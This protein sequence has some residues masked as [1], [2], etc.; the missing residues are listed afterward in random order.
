MSENLYKILE[1]KLF[2]FVQKPGRYTGGEQNTVAKNGAKLN[3]VLCF[4]ELYD[5][6]MSHYGSQILY[7]IVNSNE[8]WALERA[9]MPWED[10]EEIMRKNDIP[11][12]SLESFSPVR[13][14]DFVGFSLQYELQYT[15]VLAMLDLARISIWAKDR[16]E[17]EPIIIAG[18]IVLANPEP[19][20]DFFDVIFA[21]DGEKTIVEFCKIMQDCKEKKL[22]RK[23][24]LV[25]IAKIPNAYIPQNYEVKNTGK[26][27]TVE[28]EK[29]VVFAKSEELFEEYIPQKQIAPIV[30]TVH[31]RAAV[32]IMRGCTRGCRFCAAGYYYRPIRERKVGDIL[33]QIALSVK[34]TGWDEVGLLSL[35]TADYSQFAPLLCE[36]KNG[37]FDGVKIGIPSTRIDAM[38]ENTQI[39]L[40]EISQSSSLTIAPEA[41]SQRLRNVINKDFTAQKIFETVEILAKRK[42]NTI[43]LYFMVGLPTETDVD[44][45]EMIGLI[46]ECGKIVYSLTKRCTINVSL[47][48]FSPKPHTP[49]QWEE[50]CDLQT[51]LQRCIRVKN[52]LKSIKSINVSYRDTTLS[53]CESV[54]ARGD[55]QLSKFIYELFLNGAKFEGWNDKLSI[56]LWKKCAKNCDIDLEKYTQKIDV[57]QKLPW[58]VISTGVN[59]K[60]LLEERDKA[61]LQTT[62]K[63]CRDGCNSCGVCK[64]GIKMKIEKE[65]PECVIQEKKAKNFE[66][67]TKYKIRISYKKTGR[68]RFI[69]HRNLMDCVARAL[70]ASQTPVVFSQGFRSHPKI[71]FAQP[72]PLNA[73]GENEL[74]DVMVWDA[75]SV[76]IAKI[77]SFLPQGIELFSQ[78]LVDIKENSIEQSTAFTDWKI[79]KINGENSNVYFENALRDFLSREKIEI[80]TRK[81]EEDVLLT[82]VASEIKNLSVSGG[83]S[84][85]LPAGV[86]Y[87]PADVAKA[88]FPQS[89][90]LDFIIIRKNIGLAAQCGNES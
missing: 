21:G 60:F 59:E 55:R 83:I 61:Y 11:L 50:L 9:Y 65:S 64:S 72:L 7:H 41:G 38:D 12:Y 27:V 39:L 75:K 82:V 73:V 17:D 66:G 56:D 2:P 29:P 44:I 54:L 90:A 33:K 6:G 86:K 76:D 85:T 52:S 48:P 63:D 24:I 46:R 15:N 1:T 70:V 62:T 28:L 81:K 80:K 74:F 34:N 49:F 51:I 42:M 25:Q 37:D 77:N 88:I 16:R 45:D 78:K 23:D 57:S 32:E 4:P 87:R 89:D 69:S 84:F 47:S 5:I 26:F 18:G 58:S 31:N 20:A 79:E 36:L 68:A 67:Q 14:A 13:T 35:S 8:N 10:S 19:V 40:N 30:E 3:G 43:K 22:P 71:S 53:F